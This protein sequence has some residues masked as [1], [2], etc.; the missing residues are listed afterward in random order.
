MYLDYAA[1]TPVAAE[2]VAAMAE[3]LER[4]GI[5]GNPSSAHRWGQAA[6]RGIAMARV[7]V[8]QRI[9]ADAQTIV[10]TSGATE[11]DNLALQ[12]VMHARGGRGS[13]LVTARTEHKAVLDTAAALERRGFRVSYLDC[14]TDGLIDPAALAAAITDATV[15]ASIM[16][17]NNETG[18]V[19]DVR[20]LGEIC[21]SRG[22]LLHVD[23]AQSVGKLPIDVA[24]WPVDLMSLTAHKVYGPKGVG[25]LYLRAGVSLAAISF[26]GEQER[27]LRPGT[28][29]THQIVGMGRA[30]EL[31]DPASE[32]PRLAALKERLWHGFA[33]IDGVRRNGHPQR[34]APHV[35][36]VAFPG[37][38]GESLRLA[39]EEIAVSAGSACNAETPESSHVLT[40]M[41]L[42]DALAE[43]SLRFSV[44]RDTTAEEIDYVVGR[45]A[46]A[47]TELRR[48]S[49]GAPAWARS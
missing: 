16:H 36:N 3:C 18:V 19:Q 2:V 44:G 12:G 32:A 13:H 30:Y 37:V 20:T 15:L 10:F 22:V 40:A 49:T 24:S 48:V 34:S 17:V 5:F 38:S 7:Q 6:A 45:V 1:T 47:V 43:S 9:G 4:D 41:G 8:A 25:A 29:A 42:S 27:G 31:A 33:A 26:G 28:L 35:L 39:I 11:A 14:D 46:A 23:A 21:R